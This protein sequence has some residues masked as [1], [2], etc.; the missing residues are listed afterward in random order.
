MVVGMEEGGN[1]DRTQ[2]ALRRAGIAFNRAMDIA[3]RLGDPAL[4][5]RTLA[6][7]ARGDWFLHRG[8]AGFIKAPGR[9][10]LASNCFYSC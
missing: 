9:P 7:S 1:N 5:M 8:Y 10:V 2:D 6:W 4:E 3:R